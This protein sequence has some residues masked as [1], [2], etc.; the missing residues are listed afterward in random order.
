MFLEKTCSNTNKKHKHKPTRSSNSE[1]QSA[2]KPST[3]WNDMNSFEKKKSGEFK[4]SNLFSQTLPTRL[5]LLSTVALVLAAVP[6]SDHL[7]SRSGTTLQNLRSVKVPT[8][9]WDVRS[10][11]LSETFW[12]AF[13]DWTGYGYKRLTP[14]ML[15][16]HGTPLQ[17]KAWKWNRRYAGILQ[18]F[19]LYWAPWSKN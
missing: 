8:I 9:C 3:T 4:A 13:W 1:K 18:I 5:A 19:R 12:N 2:D 16:P 10:G 17:A 7:A 11:R 14:Q 15:L 6:G